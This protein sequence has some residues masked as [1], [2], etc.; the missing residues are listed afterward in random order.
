MTSDSRAWSWC[1]N[2]PDKSK[3]TNYRSL[4]LLNNAA[5][6]ASIHLTDGSNSFTGKATRTTLTTPSDASL[7]GI[8]AGT[9]FQKVRQVLDAPNNPADPESKGSARVVTQGRENGASEEGHTLR[10]AARWGEEFGVRDVEVDVASMGLRR[11][12]GNEKFLNAV[13]ARLRSSTEAIRKMEEEEKRLDV[14]IEDLSVAYEFLEE[15][16]SAESKQKRLGKLADELNDYKKMCIKAS[17]GG[18]K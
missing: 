8:D 1:G 17:E 9:I 4:F 15:A 10:V 12:D 11:Q 7:A 16:R 5:D 13:F 3:G 6:D 18:V 2:I 14:E